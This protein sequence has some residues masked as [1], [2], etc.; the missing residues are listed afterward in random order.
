MK[1]GD[2]VKAGAVLGKLGNSGNSSIPH[3]HFGLLDQPNLLAGRSLPFVFDNFTVVGTAD[4]SVEES[5]RIVPASP[6]AVELAYPLYPGI[7]DYP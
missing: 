2:A 5:V 6:R 1:V 3:L 7:Q 4:M